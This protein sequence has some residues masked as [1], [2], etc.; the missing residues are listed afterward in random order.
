MKFILFHFLCL[1]STVF[2]QN[3]DA[4]TT[5]LKILWEDMF[6]KYKTECIAES[7]A[8]ETDVMNTFKTLI[9]PENDDLKCYFKCAYVKLSF[10]NEN[11]NFVVSNL[12][13]IPGGDDINMVTN[14][15]GKVANE[16]D[17][18]NKVYKSLQ[19]GLTTVLKGLQ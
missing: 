14:C 12:L 3:A 7:G 6:T 11:G 15:V 19:C 18:C 5:K 8:A 10:L 13:T 16:S 4:E 9:L 17:L 1:L 2:S